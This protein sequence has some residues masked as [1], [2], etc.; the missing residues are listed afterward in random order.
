MGRTVFATLLPRLL[1]PFV[2]AAGAIPF[3]IDTYVSEA[4]LLEA[5]DD[6][7]ARVAVEQAVDLRGGGR[8]MGFDSLC[9]PLYITLMKLPISEARKR[10]PELV[11]RVRRNAE[12]KVEITVRD[13]V[14]A[15]LRGPLPEPR[16]GAAAKKLR[17][18]MRKLPKAR[19]PK[20]RVSSRVG[21]YLYGYPGRKR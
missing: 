17:A 10:L 18:L 3:E 13:E 5:T 16:P 14:V 21:Q 11:R 9:T 6:R 1:D 12:A 19:G 15:E 8:P 20:T 2:H 4:D 7:R